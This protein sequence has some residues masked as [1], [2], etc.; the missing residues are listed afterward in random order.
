MKTDLILDIQSTPCLYCQADR[1]FTLEIPGL[2]GNKC[3]CG[4]W[5][6][7]CPDC[8]KWRS[9]LLAI[10][11]CSDCWRDRELA[12]AERKRKKRKTS[13]RSLVAVGGLSN[14]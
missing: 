11:I 9:E 10:G 1:P 4:I 14:V 3:K 12:R 7:E 6:A 13:K 5:V 2:D 8:F